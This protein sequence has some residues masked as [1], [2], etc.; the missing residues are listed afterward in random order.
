MVEVVP[1]TGATAVQRTAAMTIT[2]ADARGTSFVSEGRQRRRRRRLPNAGARAAPSA[3]ELD[4]SAATATAAPGG[5][6]CTHRAPSAPAV[7]TRDGR[8]QCR[9]GGPADASTRIGSPR[10]A[11]AVLGPATPP[12]PRRRRQCRRPPPT[13]P[14]PPMREILAPRR[15]CGR[16]SRRGHA[17]RRC[18]AAG[19]LRCAAARP[20]RS[21]PAAGGPTP[22]PSGRR[23]RAAARV[24]AGRH[25]ARSPCRR[26]AARAARR[27]RHRRRTLAP[28]RRRAAR[29]RAT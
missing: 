25:G 1:R 9:G 13:A 6:R 24:L 23:P 20:L 26:A 22:T 16:P 18:A 12:P 2:T 29:L 5:R 21:A 7:P 14:P 15:R 8:T 17:A 28:C 4:A 10:A 3:D 11:A 27:C 19:A